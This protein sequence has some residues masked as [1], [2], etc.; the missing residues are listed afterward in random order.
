MGFPFPIPYD[1]NQPIP[2]NPFYYPETNYINTALGPLVIGAGFSVN[3][4]TSTI[5]STGGGGVTSVSAGFGINVSAS[6]GSVVITNTGVR[7]LTAGS[8]ISLSGTTGDITIT[9]T[10]GGGGG[11][12]AVTASAPLASSGGTTPNITLANTAVTPGPY[13]YASFTVDAQGRLTAASNGATPVIVNDF[14]AKGNLLAGT[15]ND[16]FTA[17]AVGI[18]NQVLAACNAATSGLCWTDA[19]NVVPNATPLAA[20]KIVGCTIPVSFGANGITALGNEAFSCGAVALLNPSTAIGYQAMKLAKGPF[21]VAVGQC[22]LYGPLSFGSQNVAIGDNALKAGGGV[23]CNIA[24]GY[25]AAV[26]LAS[27]FDNIAIGQG[28]LCGAAGV[29]KTV[30]IGCE[31]LSGALTASGNTAVGSYALGSV[32]GGLVNTGIGCEVGYNLTTGC[33]NTLL[34]TRAG[35]LLTSGSCNVAIGTFVCLPNPAGSCQ[36]AIGFSDGFTNSTWLTGCSSLA[37]KPGAGIIDCANSCGT[38][39]Q[40]LTS[41]GSNAVCWTTLPANG[42]IWQT[43]TPTTTTSTVATT[44]LTLPIASIR[45]VTINISVSNTTTARYHNDIWMVA[46][47]GATATTQLAAPGAHMGGSA[48]YSLAGTVSGGNL[49]IQVTSAAASSTKY[50]GVY[51]TFAV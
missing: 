35:E 38:A 20:G 50:V 29:S 51:Q 41:N 7:S 1:P 36:L 11:V 18:D 47:D 15:N 43:L 3:Y 31:A 26:A 12:T 33:F 17:L 42:F 5:S 46:Q 24:I 27:G 9:A 30:A 25:N 4:T 13:T 16:A 8:G 19:C 40:V 48:P 2:N 34:G 32:T 23:D 37:I 21:N 14:N 22:A 10:G 45:G 39:G 49:L 28:A 6:T 44:I